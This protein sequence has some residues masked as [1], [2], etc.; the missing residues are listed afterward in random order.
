MSEM[1][2]PGD[3]PKLDWWGLNERLR[4]GVG[5]PRQAPLG[6]AAE[7]WIVTRNDIR[8][9]VGGREL[10]WIWKLEVRF[11]P[12]IDT[13]PATLAWLSRVITDN[14]L[15]A[16]GCWVPEGAADCCIDGDPARPVLGR[17]Y[18]LLRPQE[19][20]D[21]EWHEAMHQGDRRK[22]PRGDGLYGCEYCA[23]E[24][25]RARQARQEEG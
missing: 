21:R 10:A 19:P 25:G 6:P 9:R 7:A 8:L 24:A 20:S 16:L 12:A 18:S 13:R 2:L 4:F 14:S 17:T 11:A 3:L 5:F 15:G 22:P 23:M 1:A